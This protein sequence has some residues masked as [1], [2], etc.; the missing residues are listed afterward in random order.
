MKK[1]LDSCSYESQLVLIIPYLEIKW[2]DLPLHSPNRL[3]KGLYDILENNKMHEP[4]MKGGGQP[5]T[6]L[7]ATD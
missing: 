6:G 3:A 4:C 5:G 1:T 2:A 7:P